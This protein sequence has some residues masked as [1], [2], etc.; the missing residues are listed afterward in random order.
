MNSIKL[1]LINTKEADLQVG[2]LNY[3]D[4]SS[5]GQ[6]GIG[7]SNTRNTNLQLGA[8]VSNAETIK[9]IQTSSINSIHN[10][11]KGIQATLGIGTPLILKGLDVLLDLNLPLEAYVFSA[12]IGRN[13]A[14]RVLG[15]VQI[16]AG[17]NICSRSLTG[18]QIGY[19]NVCKEFKG[20]QIGVVNCSINGE[21]AQIGLLNYMSNSPWYAKV[22]PGIAFRNNGNYF[23]PKR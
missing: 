17:V 14:D 2:A 1:N 22:I 18:G 13:Y 16:S 10:K 15:G 4:D 6:I 5:F 20:G 19:L 3:S 23:I 9:G 12:M 7:N 11:L 21:G 8:I